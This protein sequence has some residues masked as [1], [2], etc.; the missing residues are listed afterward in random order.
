V[1]TWEGCTT[2]IDFDDGTPPFVDDDTEV[3]IEGDRIL[4]FYFDDEG[5]V[6]YDGVEEAPGSFRLSA[7]SRPRTARMRFDA[8][9]SVLRGHF[10]E[11]GVEVRFEI[12]LAAR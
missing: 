1:A 11:A 10:E 2:R 9:R 4:L 12:R 3:R 6:V 5:P 7:R 8:S